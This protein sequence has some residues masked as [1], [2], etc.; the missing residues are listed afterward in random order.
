M[1]SKRYIKP[2]QEFRAKSEIKLP[3]PLWEN[4]VEFCGFQAGIHIA[5]FNKN[6]SRW[7]SVS[8]H[9]K[10]H[11]EIHFP[12]YIERLNFLYGEDCKLDYAREFKKAYLREYKGLKQFERRLFTVTKEGDLEQFKQLMPDPLSHISDRKGHF[13]RDYSRLTLFIWA[14]RN[15]HPKINQY[16][17][18]KIKIFFDSLRSN[19]PVFWITH[20]RDIYGYSLLD[21]SIFCFQNN[22]TIN[23]LRAKLISR[24]SNFSKS[25]DYP[26]LSAAALG[27]N[28]DVFKRLHP[29]STHHVPEIQQQYFLSLAAVKGNLEL[30]VYLH[31]EYHIPITPEIFNDAVISEHIPTIRYFVANG[32]QITLEHYNLCDPSTADYLH[33]L[34]IPSYKEKKQK[35]REILAQISPES[36]LKLP[37][38]IL[39][40][41]FTMLDKKSCPQ[42]LEIS[43]EKTIHLLDQILKTQVTNEMIDNYI[44]ESLALGKNIPWITNSVE[45]AIDRLAIFLLVSA[46]LFLLFPLV[47]I[48]LQIAIG[49]ILASALCFLTTKNVRSDHRYGNFPFYR[50][51]SSAMIQFG[52]SAKSALIE[53]ALFQPK[54]LNST[55]SEQKPDVRAHSLVKTS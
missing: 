19:T 55:V 27:M 16:L 37:A 1:E 44:K 35:L 30:V 42:D 41:A 51:L 4:I 6:S 2:Q 26:D 17:Y 40:D 5:H 18:E 46:C 48:S 9:W 22:E 34:R 54:N 52:K 28:V 10:R 20:D 49:C 12:H 45:K 8:K 11:F 7:T 3:A 36:S 53:H 32:H 47:S 31:E 21:W 33:E 50:D 24:C 38:T 39:F 43:I 15:N 14:K 13:L 29:L 25:D 23:S